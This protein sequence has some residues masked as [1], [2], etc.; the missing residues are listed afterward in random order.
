MSLL[1]NRYQLGRVLGEGAYGKVYQARDTQT[2]TD[3][4]I[5]AM[6]LA[7]P[8]I[9]KVMGEEL[10]AYKALSKEPNCHQYVACLYD[11]FIESPYVYLVLELMEGDI[12]DMPKTPDRIVALI[13]DSLSAVAYI[14]EKGYAH[15]D[16]KTEN[17]LVK[18]SVYKL[19]DL[20]MICARVAKS[21]IASCTIG[22]T[23]DLMPPE[24]DRELLGMPINLHQGQ[25]AD[26]W[27]LGATLYEVI[28]GDLP[29]TQGKN[30]PKMKQ[31]DVQL[32]N[33]EVS[34][35][36][37]S[38]SFINKL[39]NS[40]IRVDPR[41]RPTAKELLQSFKLEMTQCT[42]G[43][44]RKI[45]RPKVA[46]MLDQLGV[47]HDDDAPLVD[48]CHSL[49]DNL[50]CTIKGQT[51]S[52]DMMDYLREMF[53]VSG[54]QREVCR[55]ITKIVTDQ[56]AIDKR[57]VAQVVHQSILQSAKDEMAGREAEMTRLDR[58]IQNVLELVGDGIDKEYLNDQV[59]AMRTVVREQ[60]L[61]ASV[62]LAHYYLHKYHEFILT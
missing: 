56:D 58:V 35:G 6:A 50:K 32:L 27:A 33:D 26:I 49:K 45:D 36:L 24:L 28:V 29:Y 46:N 53:G 23:A 14:H 16:I 38:A 1:N 2:K 9:P 52:D 55:Q 41:E 47:K 37:I 61:P 60:R 57:R 17:I 3:V 7:N 13:H 44:G 8:R 62:D 30:L 54:N 39:I 25:K 5:K 31:S 12:V 48:L 19:G 18:G 20:G 40:M 51:L 10:A 21:G 42:L 43:D 59:V 4:A 22:G 34:Y 11:Y 15:R